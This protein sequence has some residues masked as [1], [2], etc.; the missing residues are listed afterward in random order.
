MT[1]EEVVAKLKELGVE[2]HVG[3]CG[4]CGSPWVTL[5]VNGETLVDD[6]EVFDL[7]ENDYR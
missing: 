2:L 4:C 3:G 1:K 7:D 5:K 6:E